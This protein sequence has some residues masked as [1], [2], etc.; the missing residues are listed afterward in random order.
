MDCYTNNSLN[1]DKT[2]EG[3][4]EEDRYIKWLDR[5]SKDHNIFYDDS[6][7]GNSKAVS[8]RDKRNAYNLGLFVTL[9]SL[10][11]KN[12]D[13]NGYVIG[14]EMIFP[15]THKDNN[16]IIGVDLSYQNTFCKRVAVSDITAFDYDDIKNHYINTNDGKIKK[17]L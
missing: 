3:M 10:Y 2:I 5:F 4:F 11:A 7:N 8:E 13:F 14:N 1:F 15:F 12:H 6:W 9:I 16:Y 17:L